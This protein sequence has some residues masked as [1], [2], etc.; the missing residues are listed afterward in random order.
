MALPEAEWI[1]VVVDEN[2]AATVLGEAVAGGELA[3]F[4]CDDGLA[5]IAVN[6]AAC[7]LTG[8]SRE[9]LLRLS[10]PDLV[11]APEEE[12]LRA[13]RKLHGGSIWNGTWR[14]R[15]KDGRAL[16]VTFVSEAARL[17]GLDGYIITLC[18]PPSD[19]R[20]HRARRRGGDGPT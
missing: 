11:A 9:E 2:F 20:A 14:L 5:Y 16:A 13:A 18:W 1:D 8:Y 3:A 17:G 10:V 4:L 19:D 7:A 15:R 6:D 12:L